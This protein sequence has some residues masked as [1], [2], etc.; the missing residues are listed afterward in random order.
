MYIKLKHININ[1]IYIYI[2]F[3]TIYNNQFQKGKRLGIKDTLTNY[4]KKILEIIFNAS[5]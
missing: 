1:Y 4:Q 3:H 5:G 2:Y